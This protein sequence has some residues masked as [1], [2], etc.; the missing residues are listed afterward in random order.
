MNLAG[1]EVET[2]ENQYINTAYTKWSKHFQNPT[3]DLLEPLVKFVHLSILRPF[4]FCKKY[5]V[6]LRNK[7]AALEFEYTLL[8]K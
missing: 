1:I 3:R 5:C 4:N 2:A 8:D 7:I 6:V